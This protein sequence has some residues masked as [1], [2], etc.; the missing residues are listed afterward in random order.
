MLSSIIPFLDAFELRESKKSLLFFIESGRDTRKRDRILFD[1]FL[2]T[3]KNEFARP[4]PTFR[5]GFMLLD[6]VFEKNFEAMRSKG[7][8]IDL[9]GLE[10]SQSEMATI[11]RSLGTITDMLSFVSTWQTMVLLAALG[12]IIRY[13]TKGRRAIERIHS[14]ASPAIPSSKDRQQLAEDFLTLASQGTDRKADTTHVRHAFAHGHFELHENHEV[15]IWDKNS[16][17]EE[18]YRSLVTDGDMVNLFNMFEMKLMLVD[19]Y[20]K[21][22]AAREFWFGHESK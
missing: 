1:E 3:F 14:W 21:V 2:S 22:V 17:G 15:L 9:F 4:H 10:F 18:T 6:Y 8:E 12:H 11:D 13:E 7:K 5:Q 16:S 20:P 19:V